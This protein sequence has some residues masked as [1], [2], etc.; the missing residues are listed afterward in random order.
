MGGACNTNGEG[1][2]EKKNAYRLLMGKPEG[3]R[4]LR[5]PRRRWLDG[6]CRGGME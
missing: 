1:E 2:E 4:P 5:R 3:R 6:S